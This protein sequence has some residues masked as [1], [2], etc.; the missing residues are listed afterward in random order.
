M[1]RH[2]TLPSRRRLRGYVKR[3]WHSHVE[4]GT[5]ASRPS[6]SGHATFPNTVRCTR[7]LVLPGSCARWTL[8][9]T[10]EEQ[11][12]LPIHFNEMRLAVEAHGMVS[13]DACGAPP[14]ALKYVGG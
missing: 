4:R 3:R 5:S 9:P 1:S 11:S 2:R 12:A 8:K 14:T 13:L 10:T 7:I 6:S